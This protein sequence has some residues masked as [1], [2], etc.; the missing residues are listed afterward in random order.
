MEYQLVCQKVTWKVHV[1]L[2]DNPHIVFA[3]A[4]SIDAFEGALKWCLDA[5]SLLPER[6]GIKHATRR[7]GKHAELRPSDP[8]SRWFLARDM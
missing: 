5:F 1:N 8:R 4:G 6:V 7:V 2:F 3:T